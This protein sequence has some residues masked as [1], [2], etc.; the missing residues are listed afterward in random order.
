MA[1][2]T[3]I[4]ILIATII[5]A[6]QTITSEPAGLKAILQEKSEKPIVQPKLY[7]Q[8]GLGRNFDVQNYIEKR[9][10]YFDIINSAS[11]ETGLDV[12]LI[13]AVII[14]ESRWRERAVSSENAVGL[15]QIINGPTDPQRNIKAGSLI[16][17]NYIK[18]CDDDL[19]MGLTA[20]NCGFAGAKRQGKPNA[21]AHKV[22]RT[23]LFLNLLNR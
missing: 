10:K 18:K 15:M 20:Y 22:I 5:M 12:R 19:L 3:K 16:L 21:Y 8:L 14:C 17:A 9:D 4:L 1:G 7:K 6:S 11:K 13:E 2:K 23:W